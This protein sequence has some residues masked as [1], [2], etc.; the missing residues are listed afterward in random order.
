VQV[1]GDAVRM[2]ADVFRRVV[3][4][5]CQLYRKLL[6]Y[7]LVLMNLISQTSVCNSLHSVEQRCCRWLLI[8]QDRV[9]SNSFLLTQEFL[10]QMLG[11]YRPTVSGAAATLQQAGLIRYSRGKMTICDRE[12]LEATTC[13]CY[14]MIKQEFE[15]LLKDDENDF[16]AQIVQQ[17]ANGQFEHLH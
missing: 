3:T 9:G 12:S 10:A 11:V 14:W 2:K 15:H 6:R 8:C 5:G 1:A 17:Q 16:S 13:E 7:T 4:P